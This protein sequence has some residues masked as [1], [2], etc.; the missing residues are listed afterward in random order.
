EYAI[1][2]TIIC[3]Q[4]ED[5][6]LWGIVDQVF[7]KSEMAVNST[8]VWR[9]T[10]CRPDYSFRIK[11]PVSGAA[12]ADVVVT[13]AQDAYSSDGTAAVP[14]EGSPINLPGVNFPI[15]VITD[16][17]RDV[18]FGW[19]LTLTPPKSTQSITLNANQR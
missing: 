1:Y 4:D 17:N 12:G 15:A 7:G 10:W 18:D 3:G 2:D 16:I 13:L 6:N 14:V 5:P 9:A 11:N 8:S 19:T